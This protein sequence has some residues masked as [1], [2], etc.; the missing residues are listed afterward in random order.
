MSRFER[1]FVIVNTTAR[2]HRAR[3]DIEARMRRVRGVT[4]LATASFEELALAAQKAA[5]QRADLVALSGGDGSFMAG[6]SALAKAFGD[7]P[8]PPTALLPG[9]TVATIARNLSRLGDPV[10]L[11]EAIVARAR[12]KPHPTLLI[13][14]QERAG[15]AT[16]VGFI[17]G[18]GLV[19]RFFELYYAEG[20]RG[21]RGA[22][23]IVA[24]VFVES[25]W[26]G[27]YARRVLD[28]LPCALSV[29]DKPLPPS[30]FSLVSS[31]VVRDLGLH[32]IVNHRAAEDPL[33]PHLVASPL[34]ARALGPRAPL[35]LMGRTIGGKGHFD[36]LVDRFS[37]RFPNGEEGPFVLDGDLLWA[38]SIT[39]RAGPRVAI[40]VPAG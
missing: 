19:A 38:S 34:P 37:I 1:A 29:N 2:L 21:E 40:A 39:V 33:R 27:P 36:D 9:G 15:P 22:A 20:A 11:L 5:D 8:L 24:R 23:S 12:L 28:P 14:T 35:V 31:S 30:A 6:L 17:F 25:F 26:G 4:V 7:K 3:P 18:T 13:E 32:M 16:R 10:H